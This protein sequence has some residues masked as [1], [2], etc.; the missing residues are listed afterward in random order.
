M[1]FSGGEFSKHGVG[2][3]AM[4][5]HTVETWCNEVGLSVNP[6]KPELVFIRKRK[7]PG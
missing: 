3:Q 6:D 4:G 7:L 2:G 1:S 5:L